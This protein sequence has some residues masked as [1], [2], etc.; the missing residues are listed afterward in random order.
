MDWSRSTRTRIQTRSPGLCVCQ[1]SL[2]LALPLDVSRV[3]GAFFIHV[4]INI[5]I[6]Y[7][8]TCIHIHFVT[9]I[10][11]SFWNIGNGMRHFK[12]KRHN[13]VAS[14]WELI[15]LATMARKAHMVWACCNFSSLHAIKIRNVTHSQR[16]LWAHSISFTF[17]IHQ[18]YIPTIILKDTVMLNALIL[19]LIIG[20]SL[21]PLILVIT[22]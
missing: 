8:G 3:Q 7:V 15:V 18:T 13:Q 19:I 5:M 6:H 14:R 10:T 1:V 11:T 22:P 20:L 21:T 2:S 12:P 4:F 17:H 9:K 16:L